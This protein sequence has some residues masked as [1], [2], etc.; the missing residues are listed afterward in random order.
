M[1]VFVNGKE[2]FSSLILAEITT[3]TAIPDHAQLYPKTDDRLYFQDGAGDEHEIVEVDVEHGEMY[4]DGYGTPVAI[5]TV[6]DPAALEGFSSSHLVDFTFVASKNGVITD[7]ANNGSGKLRITDVTHGLATGDIVT[8]NGLA[9][10]AQNGV[11]TITK[12]TNDVFDCDDISF[13]TIDETG[14]WQMGSYLLTPTGGAGT[15]LALFF[16]SATPAGTNKTYL[17]Q[18]CVNITSQVDAKAERKFGAADIGSYPLGGFITLA[19][20]DRVWLSTTGLTDATEI[21]YKH[22][23][24]SIH[25]I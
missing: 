18:L 6:G 10:A 5:T 15:Y 19:D 9:T 22:A 21:T 3:P 25:R 11:T 23:N 2:R 7:T 14:T 16:N 20:G 4:L 13:A 24:L 12:I 8:I 1:A 17:I